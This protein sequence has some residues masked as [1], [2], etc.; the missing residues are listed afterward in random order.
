MMVSSSS[1]VLILLALLSYPSLCS[2][3]IADEEPHHGHEKNRGET[4]L[5]RGKNDA[6]DAKPL[7]SSTT[8]S[9]SELLVEVEALLS[10]FALAT[11][12]H[13]HDVAMIEE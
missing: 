7:L 5:V 2:I 10:S 6:M 13:R 3:V 12:M 1:F 4:N 11:T 9:L 8:T